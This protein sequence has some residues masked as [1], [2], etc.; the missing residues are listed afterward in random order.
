MANK[1]IVFS[2]ASIGGV[3][4]KWLFWDIDSTVTTSMDTVEHLYNM[5][6]TFQVCLITTNQF[7]CTDTACQRVAALINPLL[8]VPNAL[9]AGAIW[10]ELDRKGGGVWY[11]TYGISNI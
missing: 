1:P 5:T 11:I 9:Y 6:D 10:G 4:Y 8:D 7:G 2:N 3:S